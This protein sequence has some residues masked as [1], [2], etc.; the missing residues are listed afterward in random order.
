[1]QTAGVATGHSFEWQCASD[2]AAY[3]DG[4]VIAGKYWAD[5]TIIS[6]FLPPN[7]KW[8]G[9]AAVLHRIALQCVA[10]RVSR[11]EFGWCQGETNTANAMSAYIAA[12]E[13]DTN[14]LFDAVKALL[15]GHGLGVHFSVLKTNAR[16][17]VLVGPNP[18]DVNAGY[19]ATVRAAQ[20]NLSVTRDDTTTV[21]L[22][23]V[24]PVLNL[25]Y[26]FGETNLC[27]TIWADSIKARY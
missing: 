8:L 1:M 18:G 9:L 22:D 7:T 10:A 12:F 24:V 5:G 26:A 15:A 19:L 6:D 13:S 2:L 11:V 21:S 20:E 14:T 17:S 16:L 4:N 23:A 3:F 25:H 27:G